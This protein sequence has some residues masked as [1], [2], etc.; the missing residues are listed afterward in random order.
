M[1]SPNTVLGQ[2]YRLTSPIA[3]GGMG[4]I[5]KASDT[6]LERTV[7]VKLLLPS[8]VTDQEF[9]Q[10]FQAEAKTVAALDHPNIVSVYDYG[11]TRT[12]DGSDTAYLVMQY[13]DGQS[14]AD[15][16]EQRGTLPAE[17][18]LPVVAAIAR[19]LQ[20]AHG[21]GIVHRDIKPGN[22]LLRQD[23]QALLTDF[24]IA[25]S[26]SSADLTQTG[27]VMGTASYIAP[28]QA[29]GHG[30]GAA[31]DQYALG[32]VTYHALSGQRPFVSENP[33]EVALHHIRTQPQPLGTHVAPQVAQFVATAMSKD[34]AGRFPD[35]NGFAVAA[36]AALHPQQQQNPPTSVMPQAAP[37]AMPNGHHA[38][39]TVHADTGAPGIPTPTGLTTDGN[40]DTMA[41][42]PRS[43]LTLVAIAAVVLVIAVAGGLAWYLTADD[44]SDNDGD[45][46]QT[47][48]EPSGEETTGS[49]NDDE[50]DDQENPG[51]DTDN[52]PPNGDDDPIGGCIDPTDPDCD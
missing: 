3:T 10:R 6:V 18:I 33:I 46:I 25:R 31:S 34:P 8:L 5:W 12:E 39:G 48:D 27:A 40:A 20:H 1:F 37:A 32:V 50:N 11:E 44:G 42:K 41:P 51:D 47:T 29:E 22:I 36:E 43:S 16:I 21:H 4:E 19:A 2:R 24:G 45:Q 35:A 7:A 28:E 23:G 15:L 26:S 52:D 14:L 17:E 9:I 13:V 30:A 49:D 38:T